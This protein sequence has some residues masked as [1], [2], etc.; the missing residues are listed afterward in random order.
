MGIAFDAY[1]AAAAN[2]STTQSWTH[3]PVGTPK[4]AIIVLAATNRSTAQPILGVTYGGISATE[5]TGS[6][7]LHTAGADDSAIHVFLANGIPSGA[8][9]VEITIDTGGTSYRGGCVTVTTDGGGSVELDS[10]AGND[11]GAGTNNGGA[12]TIATTASRDTVCVYVFHSGE[13]AVGS[14]STD[15]TNLGEY[16]YGNQTASY[17]RK[18]G[19]GGNVACTLTISS[20]T[21]QGFGAAFGEAVSKSGL[22]ISSNSLE[23]MRRM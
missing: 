23:S 17:D 2:S 21:W 1:S 5:I 16:D 12:V 7:R 10:S 15:G 19:A 8:Q 20:D 3:T 18:D 22:P 4:A 9:T 14:I 6:P 11:S 13:A